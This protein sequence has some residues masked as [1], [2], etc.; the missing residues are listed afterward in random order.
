MRSALQL[1]VALAVVALLAVGGCGKKGPLVY[2]DLLVP[3]APQAVQLEQRGNGLQLSFN[4]PAKD[5][6]GRSLQQPFVIEV[7]RRELNTDEQGACG[8]C[9]KDY[10]AALRIDPAFPD[11][12]QKFGSRMVLQDA[13]VR[14]GK[15]YQYR[16]TAV[17]AD[18]EAGAA[19]ETVR[20]MVCSAPPA[21]AV[22]VKTLHG[23]V[24]LLEM[25][26]ELP[27]N[28]ELVGYAIYRAAG[29][30]AL[31]FQPTATVLGTSQY[32]DQTAQPGIRYR[33]AV[34]MLVKRWDEVLVSSDLSAA[35]ASS[36]DDEI[37]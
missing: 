35:V 15:R 28:A 31:P 21:P 17:G 4:L 12:A 7:Q 33:Y 36:L 26:G 23:G 11:P 3:E 20:V 37:R 29:E 18:G 25:R 14:H 32:H 22:T 27:D 5:R 10:Q 8:E 9:P 30:E 19:A 1:P 16:L 24:I 2:P 13:D 34:R 6:R